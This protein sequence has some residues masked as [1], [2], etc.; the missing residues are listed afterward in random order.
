[1]ATDLF[2]TILKF[3]ELSLCQSRCILGYSKKYPHPLWPTL[4]WVPKNFRISKKDSSSLCRIPNPADSK[5]WGI[6]EFCKIL[7]G[8]AG[9]PN[10]IHKI[11][12]KVMEF[13]VR[14]TEHLLQDFQCRPWGGGWIFSGIA[15]SVITAKEGWANRNLNSFVRTRQQ[16]CTNFW[17]KLQVTL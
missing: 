8:F 16:H 9:I 12:L 15:H 7:N 14:L 2:R 6:P 3:I 17:G 4:N 1:M 13:P 10:K 11:L 5:S